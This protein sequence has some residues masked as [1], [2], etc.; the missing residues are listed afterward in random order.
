M[1]RNI[2]TNSISTNVL[3]QRCLLQCE[4]N[5]S[6]N[7]FIF[8][9]RYILYINDSHILDLDLLLKGARNNLPLSIILLTYKHSHVT[10]KGPIRI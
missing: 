2:I 3:S 7:Y 8:F 6:M 9:F 1:L 5:N 4:G 10:L